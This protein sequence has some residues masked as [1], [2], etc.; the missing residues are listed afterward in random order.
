[1]DLTRTSLSL[2][3]SR[4]LGEAVEVLTMAQPLR[5]QVSGLAVCSGRLF[6]YVLD[7]RA[8]SLQVRN[9]PMF[10]VRP[11]EEALPGLA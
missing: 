7:R 2:E 8:L 5:R 1:M 9:L 10:T 4:Q 3:L 6:S 11:Q